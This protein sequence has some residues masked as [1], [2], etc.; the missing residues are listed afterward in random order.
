[1]RRLHL[2]INGWGGYFV[3][4]LILTLSKSH[5]PYHGLSLMQI[6]T[7][8]CV[9]LVK[10]LFQAVLARWEYLLDTTPFLPSILLWIT[11]HCGRYTIVCIFNNIWGVKILTT[12]LLF[13]QSELSRIL[14]KNS[15]RRMYPRPCQWSPCWIDSSQQQ[16]DTNLHDL[17]NCGTKQGHQGG[18]HVTPRTKSSHHQF[19]HSIHHGSHAHFPCLSHIFNFLCPVRVDPFTSSTRP[20]VNESTVATVHFSHHPYL[21]LFNTK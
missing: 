21:G 2:V 15:I 13:L 6:I 16:A 8:P 18:Q 7:S 20:K 17:C 19:M 12:T 10:I 5:V 3:V 9:C 1:M 4:P 11:V 14:W